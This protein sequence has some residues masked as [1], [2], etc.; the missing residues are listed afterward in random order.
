VAPFPAVPTATLYASGANILNA[1]ERFLIKVEDRGLPTVSRVDRAGIVD[2]T[3]ITPSTDHCGAADVASSAIVAGDFVFGNFGASLSFTP[4]PTWTPCGA[5]SQVTCILAAPF[6]TP[7]PTPTPDCR[8][9]EYARYNAC[10]ALIQNLE[11]LGCSGPLSGNLAEAC[12]ALGEEIEERCAPSYLDPCHPPT[13]PPI[14]TPCE[15]SVIA[16]P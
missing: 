4:T 3:T 16:C 1:A 15:N 7:T 2:P 5:D 8:L 10:K 11:L 6:Q 13:P 14:P 9:I 12:E